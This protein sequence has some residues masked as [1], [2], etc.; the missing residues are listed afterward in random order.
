MTLLFD[1]PEWDFAKLD[2]TFRACEDIACGELGLTPYPSQVEV[3]TS[4]QMLDAYSSVG[5]PLMYRHWS[6]GKRFARDELMYKGGYQSLAYEIVINSNPCIAYLMEENTMT[7]QALVI[8]H[9][10]FGHNHFFRNNH[11][12]RQWTDADGI[13]DYL[14][15]ARR[16]VAECEE[17]HGLPAVERILDAAHA[18]QGQGVHR[19]LRRKWR[20]ADEEDRARERQKHEDE[21]YNPLWSTLPAS[22]RATLPPKAVSD[23]KSRLNLPEENLLYL[24]E[25]HSPRLRGWERELVRIVRVVAQYFYPQM[26][27]K[28]CNEG[29]AT[30]VHYAIM[31]R[32]HERGQISDG[33]FMEFLASHTAVTRQ[34]TLA[35]QNFSGWNPYALGFAI[36]RD[37]ERICAEPDEEDARWFPAFAGNGDPW[38]TLR[39]A[40]AEY[41]DESLIRQ[42]LGPKVMRQFRMVNLTDKASDPA[43]LVSEIH[44]DSGYRR[45]RS[46]LADQYDPSRAAPLIEA[47]DVDLFGDR[48]LLLTYVARNKARLQDASARQ[49][50]AQLQVLWGYPVTLQELDP[51][52]DRVMGELRAGV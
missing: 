12:F 17:R 3:I 49:T 16:F 21:S 25:K 38:G 7:M 44:D 24:C 28:L 30:T 39:E 26:Q 4:E 34:P 11:L 20:L 45:I 31:T 8:A 48:T 14:A 50:L 32:L 1:G 10:C 37:I 15:F 33:A 41:R 40:W 46:H 9:A 13:L 51:E 27:T 22:D 42:F 19:Y 5:L 52:T 35:D 2:R 47:T 18:L 43:L 29:C 36:M 23:A 6:F